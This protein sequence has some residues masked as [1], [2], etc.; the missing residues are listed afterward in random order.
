MFKKLLSASVALAFAAVAVSASAAPYVGFGT[1]VITNTATNT[2]YRGMPGNIFL[3]YGANIGQ[4]VYLAGE[5][6]GRFGAVT[7][8]D[9]GLKSTYVYGLSFIPGLM[10]SEHTLGYARIG[11][12]RTHFSPQAPGQ[13]A[14]VAGINLGFGLQTGLTQNWD[15]RGEYVYTASR[16]VTNVSG[17]PRTDETTLSL[18]YKFD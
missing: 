2:N 13:S 9:N 14:T 15:L 11:L 17:N 6:T 10:I 5:V 1:G 18:V 7:I 16:S 3:G 12:S 8:T 4:G